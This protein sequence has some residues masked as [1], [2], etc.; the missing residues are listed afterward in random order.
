MNNGWES[1]KIPIV[2][3]YGYLEGNASNQYHA[4]ARLPKPD[5]TRQIPEVNKQPDG[6]K[7]GWEVLS[8]R[9][10]LT[11]VPGGGTSE[12]YEKGLEHVQ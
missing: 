4:A 3:E 10:P 5:S 11:S 1:G 9:F 6:F 12:I 8:R 7:E 2:D